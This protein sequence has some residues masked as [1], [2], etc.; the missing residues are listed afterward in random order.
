MSEHEL[1]I[2]LESALSVAHDFCDAIVSLKSDV[3]ILQD[4][5]DSNNA[6]WALIIKERDARIDALVNECALRDQNTGDFSKLEQE[7]KEKI[8]S[9]QNQLSMSINDNAAHMSTIRTLKGSLADKDEAFRELNKHLEEKNSHIE[10]KNSLINTLQQKND[11]LALYMPVID[12]PS[13]ASVDSKPVKKKTRK[14][15]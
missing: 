9:L 15:G 6:N 1:A 4:T 12:W 7:Y 3:K 10:E 13:D 5:I 8:A 11:E 14:N 2:R